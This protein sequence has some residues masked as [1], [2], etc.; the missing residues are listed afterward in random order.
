MTK[1]ANREDPVEMDNM[2]RVVHGLTNESTYAFLVRKADSS[3]TPREFVTHMRR[4][5]E[6][7]WPRLT[8]RTRTLHHG[9]K[10]LVDEI[11]KERPRSRV[12]HP[13]MTVR[14]SSAAI[15]ADSAR[16]TAKRERIMILFEEADAS[17]RMEPVLAAQEAF[18]K[19]QSARASKPRKLPEEAQQKRIAKRY[20]ESKQNGTAYGVVKALAVEYGVSPTTIQNVVKSTRSTQS[21]SSPATGY[22]R[23]TVQPSQQRRR[24]KCKQTQQ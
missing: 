24:N 12:W 9:M 8:D 6:W 16:Y 2:I 10:T 3:K 20:W 23:F 4:V 15:R 21:T 17:H 5:L 11:D 13:P 22:C 19:A 18:Q 1:R 7:L 14:V